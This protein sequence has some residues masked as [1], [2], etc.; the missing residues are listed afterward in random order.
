MQTTPQLEMSKWGMQRC[1]AAR[2][3]GA[4][5]SLTRERTPGR[6]LK[7]GIASWSLL[8]RRL[9]L[10]GGGELGGACFL[11]RA[12][13]DELGRAAA[14]RPPR[15]R[16][17][18]LSAFPLQCGGWGMVCLFYNMGICQRVRSV[19]GAS[20][21][22]RVPQEKPKELTDCSLSGPLQ[23]KSTQGPIVCCCVPFL[24]LLSILTTSLSAQV[25]SVGLALSKSALR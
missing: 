13:E 15:L 12:Q 24:R 8:H 1:Q 10:M 7:K 5:R 25:T 16:K 17:T 11:L 20:Q 9:I 4:R 21:M 14:G 2:L 19:P 3:T 6:P 22:G 23:A 18:K